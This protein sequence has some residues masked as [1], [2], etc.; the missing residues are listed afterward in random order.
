MA[1]NGAALLPSGSA[2]V[3]ASAVTV[4]VSHL[5]ALA[6]GQYQFWVLN[7]SGQSVEV[8]AAAFGTVVEFYLRVDLDP[9]TGDTIRDPITG[10]PV[11]VTD[12]TIVSATRTNS[13]TGSDDPA[14]T[15]VRVI[16]DSTSDGS[17]A[18]ESHAVFLTIESSAASTPNNAR[19][20]WRRTG[21]GGNGALSF[22]NFAGYWTAASSPND[23]LFRAA[24]T[25]VGGIRG[26]EISVGF[27]D[28]DR[29]PVGFFYRGYLL[30]ADGNELMVDTLRGAWNA[31]PTLS[32]VSLFDADADD[33]LPG[34]S[35][36]GIVTANVRNC[37]VNSGVLNCGNSLDVAAENPYGGYLG[38]ELHLEP[39]G[40]SATRSP[41][42][43]H[44]G[45][46]P[47]EVRTQ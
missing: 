6:S 26:D 25:G 28:L 8:P 27:N 38:F 15:S 47:D 46:L 20:L 23:Y 13:Y 12:S 18:A 11:L 31:D 30:D 45:E 2:T 1:P 35:G 24:G 7:R 32:R 14:V 22:G 34:V 10:D 43:T 19:F 33:L 3:G 40:G 42:A 36:R 37:R 4:S 9:V 39:K 44:T 29:P 41:T 5:K 16:V 17:P 21:V